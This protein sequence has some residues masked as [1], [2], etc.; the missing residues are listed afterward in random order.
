MISKIALFFSTFR[1][2][3]AVYCNNGNG[4]VFLC[5]SGMSDEAIAQ[6]ACVS[7]Y[8][9][10]N[11]RRCGNFYY[12]YEA[13]S[14]SCSCGGTPIGQLEFIYENRGYT[15]V[16]QDYSG[17][18]DNVAGNGLFVRKRTDSCGT[19][20]WQLILSNLGE[21]EFPTASPTQSPTNVPTQSPTNVP[22]RILCTD[23][24]SWCVFPNICDDVDFRQFCPVSCDD[25]HT[26]VPTMVPTTIPTW[27]C[28]GR[29]D[30]FEGVID[31]MLNYYLESEEDEE[32]EESNE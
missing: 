20:S 28:G 5:T 29:E 26:G 2:T 9:T 4:G 15:W 14:G 13:S 30:L 7:V 18:I 11:N 3:A 21:T 6:A 10:C 25:C 31:H 1:L 12:Y 22:T 23:A 16:G 27:D 17:T 32:S 19:N 8:T 24:F